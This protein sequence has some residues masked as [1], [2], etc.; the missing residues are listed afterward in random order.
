[1]ALDKAIKK[2]TEHRRP[3]Y[4]AKAIDRTCCNHGG[5]G[6]RHCSGQCGWCKENR[7]FQDTREKERIRQALDCPED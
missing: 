2:G 7:L 1:M 6:K 5:K 4:G 3:Y